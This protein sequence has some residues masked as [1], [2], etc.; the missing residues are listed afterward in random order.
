MIHEKDWMGIWDHSDESTEYF[1]WR[2]IRCHV[3]LGLMQSI[4]NRVAS[5]LLNFFL[6]IFTEFAEYSYTD[7][8]LSGD[9]NHVYYSF[10]R[11]H[12]KE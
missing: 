5:T 3:N 12:T 2:Q 1:I 10:T 8:S 4:I 6:N 9:V 7:S 11:P